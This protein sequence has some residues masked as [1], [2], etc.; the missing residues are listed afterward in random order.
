MTGVLLLNAGSNLISAGMESRIR[1]NRSAL[2]PAASW[3]PMPEPAR[4]PA[5]DRARDRARGPARVLNELRDGLRQV[6]SDR[7]VFAMLLINTAFTLAVLPIAMVYM[8]YLFNVI[9]GATSAQAAFPQAAVWAGIVLGSAAASRLMTRHRPGRLMAGALL[10]LAVH[11]SIMAGLAGSWARLGTVGMSA[12]CTA[13]NVVAG[14]AGAFFIV[15]LY[16]F[17]HAR[18]AEQF[19]GRFW[20]LE[21][22]LRTAAMCA[23]YFLAGSIAQRLPITAIFGGTGVVLALLSVAVTRVKGLASATDGKTVAAG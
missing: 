16:S 17:F 15:P 2:T 9:L 4:G 12:A 23:G 3:S 14:G 18:A 21:G 22:A 6:R 20:G 7:A 5:R 19:R 13:A 1:V 11:T 10:V 8:P